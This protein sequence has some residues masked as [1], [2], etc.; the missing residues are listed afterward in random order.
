MENL[1]CIVTGAK[2]II[3]GIGKTWKIMNVNKNLQ[4][5]QE[6]KLEFA[7]KTGIG[8]GKNSI[9]WNYLEKA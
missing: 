2:N 1:A 3:I 9:N 5:K 8:N 6:S 4:E 7:R